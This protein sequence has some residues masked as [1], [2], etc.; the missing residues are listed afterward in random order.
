M[1]RWELEAPG[2]RNLALREAARPEP[3]PGEVLVRV[4][5]VSLNYRDLLIWEGRMGELAKP[6]IPGSDFSGEVVEVGPLVTRFGVGDRV[7]GL[8]VEDWVDGAAPGL[9]TNTVAVS[10][11]LA[12]FAVVREDMLVA[13]PLTLGWGEASTLPTAGLTAWMAVVE[14]GGVRAGQTWVVQGTGGVSLF[15]VQFAAAHG[16]K[17]IL[18]SSSDEKLARGLELGASAGVNYR[19]HPD[20]DRQVM[21]LTKGRGADAV[22]EMAAG[23][24]LATSVEALTYGGR[25]LLVGLLGS[26]RVT[27][28]VGPLLLRRAT[29]SAIGVGPRRALE[30]MIRAIDSLGIRPVV[31]AAYDFA[32]L[33]AAVA[34]LQTGAVGKVVVQVQASPGVPRRLHG[35]T[36]ALRH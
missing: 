14:I 23:E 6:F 32:D 7:I 5:A 16:A 28:P 31:A 3:G 1:L 27:T 19:T 9:R 34:H 26:D 15:A 33:P 13:A 4:H 21:A 36:L 10:G 12:E 17:V 29:L 25:I 20:W 22:I 35:G 30:D 8:D 18:T 24:N 2:V 11:R